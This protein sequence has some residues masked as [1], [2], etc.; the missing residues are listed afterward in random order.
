MRRAHVVLVA[1]AALTAEAASAQQQLGTKIMG[2][3]GIDAGVQGPPGL[4]VLD[5]VLGFDA[6]KVRDRSGATL[7]IQGLDIRARANGLGLAYTFA[8]RSWPYLTMAASAPLAHVSVN[9]DEPFASVDRWGFGDLFVQPIE[10]GWSR[11]RYNA[12]LGYDFFAPTGKFEPKRGVGVGR[13]YW[14][15][16]FSLGG[17]FFSDTLRTIRA[18]ALMSYDLNAKMRGIDITRGNMLSVQGGAGVTARRIWVVGVAGYALWQVSDDRGSNL[19]PVLAGAR[20]RTYGLGP[21]V[22]VV[23]PTIG[24]RAEVRYEWDLGTRARPQGQVFA[25]GLGYRAW[26]PVKPSR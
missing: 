12:V 15:H 21:E 11:P 20:T 9:S 4:Y 6:S 17:A 25:V 22:D 7:P 26:A 13:G 24:L 19:P 23:I 14:T 2:G 1:A 10:A 3:L 8:P 18:S 5:R 16:Q